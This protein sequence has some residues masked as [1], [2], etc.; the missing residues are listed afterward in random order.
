MNV[1]K[2][3]ISDPLIRKIV[4]ACY[5]DYTGR[6]IK[7][8]ARTS[9]HLSNFWDGGSRSY[10]VAYHL[11]SGLTKEASPSTTSP[12]NEASKSSVEIPE[13]VVLVEHSIFQGKDVGIRIYV[14]PLNM[15]KLLPGS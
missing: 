1:V 13:G 9:Y 11:E 7:I 14:N 12:F 6:K 5:P 10:V 2:A 3:S 4:R 8:E 15:A